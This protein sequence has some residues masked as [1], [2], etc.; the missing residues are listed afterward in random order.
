MAYKVGPLE[1]ELT[2]R[3]FEADR[4][5]CE[6]LRA[7]DAAQSEYWR[8]IGEAYRGAAQLAEEYGA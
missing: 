6:A 1:H 3:C 2:Q 8:G 7:G 5:R 4:R